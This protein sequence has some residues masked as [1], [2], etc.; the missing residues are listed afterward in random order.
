[1]S[2]SFVRKSFKSSVDSFSLKLYTLEELKYA[3]FKLGFYQF[4]A[5]LI[6]YPLILKNELK[7]SNKLKHKKKK[8]NSSTRIAIIKNLEK[9]LD[10]RNVEKI[11][12]KK[13]NKFIVNKKN[14]LIQK[15]KVKIKVQKAKMNSSIIAKKL[16]PSRLKRSVQRAEIHGD[17]LLFKLRNCVSF[18]YKV[19]KDALKIDGRDYI[20]KDYYLSDDFVKLLDALCNNNSLEAKYYFEYGGIDLLRNKVRAYLEVKNKTNFP[21]SLV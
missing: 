7:K 3:Y 18:T 14:A 20:L 1:M 17:L 2:Q 8:N 16:S 4:I 15:E 19:Y 12:D 21:I 13:L 10:N 9:D 5:F 11:V 6:V